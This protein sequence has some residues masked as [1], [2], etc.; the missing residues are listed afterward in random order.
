MSDTEDAER[1]RRQV[2]PD[3]LWRYLFVDFNWWYVVVILGS[4]YTNS[5]SIMV[6]YLGAPPRLLD[7]EDIS[8]GN[9]RVL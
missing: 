3:F 5:Y 7:V 9:Q 1:D 8:Q 4:L 2:Q 6:N